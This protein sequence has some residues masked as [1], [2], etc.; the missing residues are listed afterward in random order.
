MRTRLL[1]FVGV[2]LTVQ[3]QDDPLDVLRR[4]SY[5]VMKTIDRMPKYVCT[6]T[7]DRSEYRL[8]GIFRADSC[9]GLAAEKERAP[10]AP[11]HCLRSLAV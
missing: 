6:Q 1:L 9:D 10:E 7:I 8:N 3:A 11:P 5:N 2:A 4:V